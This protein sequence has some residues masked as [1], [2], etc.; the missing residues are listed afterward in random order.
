V[1]K[2]KQTKGQMTKSTQTVWMDSEGG[3]LLV[4]KEPGKFY[5]P[6]GTM[7][8]EKLIELANAAADAIGG[9]VAPKPNQTAP[10]TN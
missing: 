7:G 4:E 5:T 8:R 10:A 1:N 3:E 6:L 2:N 9:I